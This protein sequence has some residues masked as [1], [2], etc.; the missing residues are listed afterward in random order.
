MTTELLR[1][2]DGALYLYSDGRPV[3]GSIVTGIGQSAEGELQA[4]VVVP[5]RHAVLGEQ[6]NVVPFVRPPMPDI[7]TR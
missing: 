7:A 1:G 4:I 6:R 5:M 2:H 3:S